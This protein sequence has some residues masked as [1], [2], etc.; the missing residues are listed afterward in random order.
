MLL[1]VI[2]YFSHNVDFGWRKQWCIWGVAYNFLYY[3]FESNYLIWQRGRGKEVKE[4]EEEEQE[5]RGEKEKEERKNY[6]TGYRTIL[7]YS[8]Y[9]IWFMCGNSTSS[10]TLL[11][12]CYHAAL[13]YSSLKFE[14]WKLEPLKSLNDYSPKCNEIILYYEKLTFLQYVK[15]QSL[16]ENVKRKNASRFSLYPL[17]GVDNNSNNNNKFLKKQQ[18]YR[19]LKKDYQNIA[20]GVPWSSQNSFN[21]QI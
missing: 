9:L 11:R 12:F 14:P 2:C 15:C 10:K 13:D 7:E 3:S 20:L 8:T 4:A 18:V 5:E 19:Q 17:V 6:N 1:D 16:L 21:P